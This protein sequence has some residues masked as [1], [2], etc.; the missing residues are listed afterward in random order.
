M[1]GG[2]A[3]AGLVAAAVARWWARR[4]GDVSASTRAVVAAIAVT[5]L[6]V[7][8]LMLTGAGFY[9][10][11]WWLFVVPA[12]WLVAG[13][14]GVV[15]QHQARA[16]DVALGAPR[17][18]VLWSPWL[19]GAV[20]FG[21]LDAVMVCVLVVWVLFAGDLDTPAVVAV[22]GAAASGTFAMAGTQSLRRARAGGGVGFL[23]DLERSPRRGLLAAAG[24]SLGVAAV[25]AGTLWAATLTFGASDAHMIAMLLATVPG[26]ALIGLS[27]MLTR[28]EPPITVEDPSA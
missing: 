3:G 7:P 14:V 5:A 22:G 18:P 12:A 11:Q 28:P 25:V 23:E 20:T 21:L 15:E 2:L 6:L 17:R 27:W 26:W 13:L 16:R 24:G 4:G 19:V 9:F 1:G 8:A 10:A